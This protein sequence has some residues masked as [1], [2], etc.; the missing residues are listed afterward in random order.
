MK[1][2]HIGGILRDVPVEISIDD[3][4]NVLAG[5]KKEEN[6][7][8]RYIKGGKAI[9]L[10]DLVFQTESPFQRRP[11][12]WNYARDEPKTYHQTDYSMFQ[13]STMG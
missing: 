4:N 13:L 12:K 6:Q 9:P 8:M 1:S 11:S 5:E 10:V 3:I 7:V 2:D